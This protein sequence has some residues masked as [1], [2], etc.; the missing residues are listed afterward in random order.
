MS[1]RG[2]LNADFVRFI[3]KNNGSVFK[4]CINLSE[5]ESVELA[6]WAGGERPEEVLFFSIPH[7]EVGTEVGFFNR[8]PEIHWNTRFWDRVH[9]EG[10]FKVHSTQGPYQGWMSMTLK[11]VGHE[12]I[13]S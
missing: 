4:L 5:Q 6:S 10:F 3:N 8:D 7:D 9:T 2:G 11:G 1:I 13:S 12:H